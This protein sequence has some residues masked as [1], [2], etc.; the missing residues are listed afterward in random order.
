MI[1]SKQETDLYDA[2]GDLDQVLTRSVFGRPVDDWGFEFNPLQQMDEKQIAEINKLDMESAQAELAAGVI[3]LSHWGAQLLKK[4]IYPTLDSYWVNDLEAMEE[5]EA[6][7]MMSQLS[8]PEPPVM[9]GAPDVDVDKPDVP[10]M[11]D[12]PGSAQGTAE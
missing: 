4:G 12:D 1:S 8:Q 5:L 10:D 2:L 6:E 3:T 9:E 11:D 7:T